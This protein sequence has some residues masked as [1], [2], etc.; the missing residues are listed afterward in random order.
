MNQ[1][2]TKVSNICNIIYS[3]FTGYGSEVQTL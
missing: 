3:L 2:L 1:I